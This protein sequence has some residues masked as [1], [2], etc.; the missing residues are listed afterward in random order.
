[1]TGASRFQ[2]TPATVARLCQMDS[3]AAGWRFS[4]DGR[5]FQLELSAAVQPFFF[6]LVLLFDK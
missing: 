4:V 3:S 1:M 5:V 6:L 2:H